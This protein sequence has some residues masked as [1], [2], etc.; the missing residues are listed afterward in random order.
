M[1]QIKLS[2]STAAA[3][4]DRQAE[5]RRE[6]FIV[7]P[8]RWVVERTFSWS[9]RNRGLAKDFENLGQTLAIF[10]TPSSWPSG[11]LARA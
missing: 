4:G 9:G 8:R 2:R 1:R 5:P 6:G 10:A 7:L 11:E 3:H